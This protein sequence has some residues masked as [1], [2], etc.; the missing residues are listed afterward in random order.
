MAFLWFSV[1]ALAVLAAVYY[2]QQSSPLPFYRPETK[3]GQE[4]SIQMDT[5][6]LFG[7]T[8]HPRP[9]SPRQLIASDGR[10]DHAAELGYRGTR[11]RDGER[12]PAQA[13]SPM[14]GRGGGSAGPRCRKRSY[15]QLTT[16][17]PPWQRHYESWT[18]G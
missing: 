5:I 9:G 13:V 10:L 14:W 16:T 11:R 4:K 7:G 17:I 12:V 18:V 2:R 15:G 3:M 6:V 8:P 1:P